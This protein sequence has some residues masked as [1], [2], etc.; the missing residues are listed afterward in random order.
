MRHIDYS[1]CSIMQVTC[2]KC[3]TPTKRRTN[4]QTVRPSVRLLDGVWHKV[5]NHVLQFRIHNR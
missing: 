5:N 3:Q 2:I 4:G 1:V